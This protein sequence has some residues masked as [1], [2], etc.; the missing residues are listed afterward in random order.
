MLI[1]VALL[2]IGLVLLTIGADRLVLSAARV[3]TRLGLSPI[4]I[5]ALVIGV[6]TSAPE[7]LVSVV[8]AV[9]GTLDLAV[10]NIV[11]SNVANLSL[12]VGSAALISP[13]V[14]RVET[15]RREGGLMLAG[16]LLFAAFAWDH[17]LSWWEGL[18]LLAGMGVA[19]WLVIRWARAD[20]RGAAQ[21]E[22]EVAEMEGPIR[23]VPFEIVIGVI[24]IAATLAGAELLVRGAKTLADLLDLS[25]GFVGLTIVAVGTS[26]P[27]LA[28]AVA[29][30]RRREGALVVGNVLG[31]NMFNSLLV[32]G[33][34]ALA[35]PA[36]LVGDFRFPLVAMVV[37]SALAGAFARSGQ[38]VVR[39]EGILLLAAFAA[40]V[41]GLL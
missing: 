4:L 28:T 40:L 32:G 19:G 9:R 14:S 41:V 33:S 16:T 5:G 17:R 21:I 2:V 20:R 23:S 7:L 36:A 39:L 31:S 34:A 24:S 11:G 35:G 30:A 10:G 27:E 1:A 29:A 12:V 26:L 13:V 22:A 25:D 37:V 18:I 15:L 3:S 38:R 8:A 6:G